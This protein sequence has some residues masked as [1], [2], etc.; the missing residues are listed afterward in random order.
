MM[1][2]KNVWGKSLHCYPNK[3]WFPDQKKNVYSEVLFKYINRN[4]KSSFVKVFYGI[5][6]E[7]HAL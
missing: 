1:G 7:K 6:N 5:Q 2:E 3:I 4:M